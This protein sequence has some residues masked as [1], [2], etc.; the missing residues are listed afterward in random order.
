MEK[1]WKLNENKEDALYIHKFAISRKYS[2]SGLGREILTSIKAKAIQQDINYLRLDC[3]E[4]NH[5]LRKY[6]KSCEF[7]L[8]GIAK[9]GGINL[10]LYEYDIRSK[11][12]HN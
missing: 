1:I 4:H 8:K 12:R 10:A 9:A 11:M 5:K 2:N 3:V 6:Y 7:K